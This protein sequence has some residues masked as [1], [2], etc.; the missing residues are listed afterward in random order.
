MESPKDHSN[1]F[2]I[3]NIM[4]GRGEENCYTLGGVPVQ[5]DSKFANSW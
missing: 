1:I 4:R 3:I 5:A 2:I